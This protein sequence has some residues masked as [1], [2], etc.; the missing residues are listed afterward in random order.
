MSIAQSDC[1]DIKRTHTLQKERE[2]ETS[3]IDF[4]RE[5]LWFFENTNVFE[6]A[7]QALV[8]HIFQGHPT[9]FYCR[10][11]AFYTAIMVVRQFRDVDVSAFTSTAMSQSQPVRT[12][13]LSQAALVEA[14]SQLHP[15]RQLRCTKSPDLRRSRAR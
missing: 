12:R 15:Q 1:A 8:A 13:R 4:V 11:G 5:R 9:R 3:T 2:A 10:T 6:S 7:R 14:C